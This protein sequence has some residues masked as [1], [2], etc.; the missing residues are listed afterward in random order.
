MAGCPPGRSLKEH[1]MPDPILSI[2]EV[3]RLPPRIFG[4]IR[5]RKFIGRPAGD[6]CAGFSIKVEE[7]TATQFLSGPGGIHIPKPGTGIFKD[8]LEPVSCWARDDEESYHS[9]GF[10]VAGL[11]LNMPLDGY[12]KVTPALKG[13]W[14]PYSIFA[15]GY[16]VVEPIY[17]KFYLKEEARVQSCEFEIKLRSWFSGRVI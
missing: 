11:H 1:C 6:P 8:V 2:D 5:W 9:I 17:Y 4:T 10:Q 16:R 14:R 7:H 3:L 15:R 12:Y 13:D